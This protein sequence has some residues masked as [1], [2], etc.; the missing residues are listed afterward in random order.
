MTIF[1]TAVLFAFLIDHA[2]SCCQVFAAQDF[3]WSEREDLLD[4]AGGI[5]A[6]AIQPRLMHDARP[7]PPAFAEDQF[8]W[9]GAQFVS[10]G[11]PAQ[12]QSGATPDVGERNEPIRRFLP[13][14]QGAINSGGVRGVTNQ[15]MDSK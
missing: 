13:L 12:D 6:Q 1:K 9:H 10:D 5:A 14:L 11:A 8:D 3:E 4:Y 7:S 2:F 15:M